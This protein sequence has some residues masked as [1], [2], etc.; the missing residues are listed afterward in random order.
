MIDD[1]QHFN[2]ERKG[3]PTKAEKTHNQVIR[4]SGYFLSDREDASAFNF[5]MLQGGSNDHNDSYEQKKKLSKKVMSQPDPPDSQPDE[6]YNLVEG[7]D[8]DALNIQ[9]AQ[10]VCSFCQKMDE[11]LVGP[12]CKYEGK[13]LVGSPLFFHQDCIELNQYSKFS[14]ESKKWVNIG[15]AL[16]NLVHREQFVCFRC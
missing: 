15:K 16:Q 14:I 1:Q 2:E 6:D 7:A 11:P 5:D 10:K 12:F 4:E 13:D 9:Q 8:A 3:S